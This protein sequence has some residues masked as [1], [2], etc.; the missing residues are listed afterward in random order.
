MKSNLFQ[1]LLAAA[2]VL[3]LG[4]GA[5]PHHYVFELYALDTNLA[6]GPSATRAEVLA[7]MNGHILGK[8]VLV[9]RF[10]RP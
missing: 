7:A 10:H 5:T 3:M 9:G 2:V 4:V 8:A 1:S 6:L